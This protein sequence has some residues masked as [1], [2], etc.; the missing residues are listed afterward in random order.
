MRRP[1][2]IANW[3]MNT[4]LAEASV[5]ASSIKHDLNNTNAEVV[6]CPPS[7]WLVP[8]AEILY[9]AKNISIGAQN[10]FWEN[11][12]AGG[13][14]YT[15]E[16]APKMLKGVTK[17][18]II[19]HSERRKY[20]H[21]DLEMIN[22]KIKATIEAGLT[23]VVCIGEEKKRR[24]EKRIYIE[25][26]VVDIAA[27]LWREISCIFRGVTHEEMEKIIIVYEPVWAIS[28]GG[29]G[30]AADGAYASAVIKGIRKKIA[31]LYS[32]KIAQEIRFLYGGSVD[33]KNVAEF[34]RQPEIN[35][36]LVGAASLKLREFIAICRIDLI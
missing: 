30:E 5:L 23:P 25:P 27:P 24:L 10:V 22:K 28:T 2:I 33:S 4:S 14:H 12:S 32:K 21:E 31:K 20:L 19:G 1:I 15:G 9:G 36:C 26:T 13:G 17:Y 7:V 6:I 16:I 29:K 34:L 18:V 11:P 8:V 3:K 35:G